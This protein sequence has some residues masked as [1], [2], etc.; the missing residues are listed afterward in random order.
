[1]DSEQETLIDSLEL[2]LIQLYD[3]KTI[4]DQYLG[5]SEPE[6]IIELVQSIEEQLKE[7]YNEKENSIVV[8][9]N[10]LRIHGPKK[11]IIKKTGVNRFNGN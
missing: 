8:Q 1:M 11:I 5:T 10:R 2:Q 3:E 9:G 6:R 7:L 4:L